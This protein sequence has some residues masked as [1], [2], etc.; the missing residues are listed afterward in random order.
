MAVFEITIEHTA[1]FSTSLTVEAD[2]ADDAQRKAEEIREA[3]VDQGSV[4]W[5]VKPPIYTGIIEG[6][7]WALYEYET[8]IDSVKLNHSETIIENRGHGEGAKVNFCPGAWGSVIVMSK[9]QASALAHTIT[10]V[11]SGR[12]GDEVREIGFEGGMLSLRRED[13][14][15][16]L[17]SSKGDIPLSV[18]ANVACRWASRLDRCANAN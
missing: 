9:D 15:M 7:S 17:S 1:R 8:D 18:A 16:T 2:N 10:D 13:V 6:I 5:E 3:I 12:V 4:C 11:L 14:G